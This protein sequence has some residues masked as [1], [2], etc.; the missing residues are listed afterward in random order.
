LASDPF[1][2]RINPSG[3]LENI[4]LLIKS[5]NVAGEFSVLKFT[6]S[7]ELTIPAV[8]V[9]GIGTFTPPASD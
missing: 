8:Q 4:K 1:Y 6:A 2:Q 3:R 7:A 9:S 5:A